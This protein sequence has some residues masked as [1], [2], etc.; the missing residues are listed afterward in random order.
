MRGRVR[1]RV[2]DC[3]KSMPVGVR[4]I[5]FIRAGEWRDE[6]DAFGDTL[7][8]TRGTSLAPNGGSTPAG[9]L[10]EASASGNRVARVPGRRITVVGKEKTMSSGCSG[11]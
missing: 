4:C 6:V 2:I 8:V 5:R 1:E 3:S 7:H 11:R 10:V 9:L